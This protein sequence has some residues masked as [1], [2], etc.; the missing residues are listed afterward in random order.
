MAIRKEAIDMKRSDAKALKTTA[1]LALIM[2]GLVGAT[3]CQSPTAG[4]SMPV[5]LTL[6][7]QTQGSPG[8]VLAGVTA[9]A[10]SVELKSDWFTGNNQIGERQAAFG[11]DMGVVYLN[12]NPLETVRE[13]FVSELTA[14]GHT[15]VA[16][17]PT[18]AFRGRVRDFRITTKTTPMYWD[19]VA[20]VDVA[21]TAGV[22]GKTSVSDEFHYA[23]EHKQR[24][25]VW[26][27]AAMM[28]KLLAQCLGDIR[29]KLRTDGALANAMRP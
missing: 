19:V 1:I 5:T 18:V 22:T 8:G 11:S 14:A 29:Q 27:S 2:A 17:D 15:V 20:T 3:G 10:V 26:P 13:V 9:S 21:F 28:E 6:P 4:G 24:T 23:S 16:K 7:D 12:R 25:Y